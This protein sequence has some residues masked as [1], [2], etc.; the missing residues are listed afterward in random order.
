M[1]TA[2][3]EFSA[4]GYES[5]ATAILQH[6]TTQITTHHEELP[7]SLDRRFEGARLF[8]YTG[9][10]SRATTLFLDLLSQDSSNV[11]ILGFLGLTAAL[12]GESA[13]ASRISE[14]LAGVEAPYLF[15]A[16]TMWRARIA[17][18]LGNSSDA[19]NLINQARE[20]RATSALALPLHLDLAFTNLR[21]DPRFRELLRPKG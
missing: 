12:Q 21:N 19:I 13:E 3:L 1:E 8:L 14:V 10:F 4:H 9:Q 11:E 16:N 18:A 2:A 15:G 7:G 5:Y 20:Q 17:A 6:A